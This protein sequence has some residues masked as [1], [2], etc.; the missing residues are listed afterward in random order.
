M[1]LP[2]LKGGVSCK[3]RIMYEVRRPFGLRPFGSTVK[4]LMSVVPCGHWQPDAMRT[5]K[6]TRR[7]FS[8]DRIGFEHVVAVDTPVMARFKGIGADNTDPRRLP[9]SE[10]PG[11]DGQ[12]DEGA[13]GQF[14]E[15]VAP[16]RSGK[17]AAGV[18]QR[19]NGRRLAQGQA[20]GRKPWVLFGSGQTMGFATAFK[21]LKKSL[22]PRSILVIVSAF[23]RNPSGFMHYTRLGRGV[24][25]SCRTHSKIIV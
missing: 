15:P 5:R 12:G 7:G 4:N 20:A 3:R 23:I 13:A 2:A 24:S 8:P 22:M 18:E 10:K 6:T 11:I 17:Q 19:D 14:H 25:L 16:D 21:S 1:N 9:P